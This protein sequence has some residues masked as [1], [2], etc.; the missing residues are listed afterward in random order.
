MADI[1]TTYGALLL[2]GMAAAGLSGIVTIQAFAYVKLYP[3]DLIH[4]KIMVS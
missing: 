2:G 4:T 1:P 3:S